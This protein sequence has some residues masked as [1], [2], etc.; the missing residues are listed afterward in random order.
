ME[1]T[2]LC[3]AHA[4]ACS[5]SHAS[6]IRRLRSA[7]IAFA[8]SDCRLRPSGVFATEELNAL[9]E[10]QNLQ[11][12]TYNPK[13]EEAA[14][15]HAEDMVRRGFNSHTGSNGSDVSDRVRKAGYEWCFV[16][17][18]IAKGQNGLKTVM[19]DWAQLPG[20][21]ANMLSGDAKEFALYQA[22][23][24]TWVMVLASLCR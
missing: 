20:H 22:S 9:R 14:K 23:D 13:F 21:R 24:R 12:F 7:H 15:S 17:E 10:S 19:A 5:I 18:D 6:A 8:P 1:L 2:S 3:N 11:A 16:A 4:P